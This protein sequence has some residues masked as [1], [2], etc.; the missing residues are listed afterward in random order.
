[1][2]H[3]VL[4]HEAHYNGIE[5][6]K[7]SIRHQIAPNYFSDS[8]IFSSMSKREIP[9]VNSLLSAWGRNHDLRGLTMGEV[10]SAVVQ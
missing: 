9:Y 7:K 8:R 1:V 2:L 10:G 3:A 5:K 6:K 4:H